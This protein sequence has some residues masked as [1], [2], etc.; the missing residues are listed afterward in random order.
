[1]LSANQVSVKYY[2]KLNWN[3]HENCY[4]NYDQT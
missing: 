3:N 1:M 2:C 4:K